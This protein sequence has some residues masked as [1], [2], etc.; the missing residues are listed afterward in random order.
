MSQADFAVS[1]AG[2]EGTVFSTIFRQTSFATFLTSF[3]SVVMLSQIF[4]RSGL[5]SA[6]TAALEL[7]DCL[8][9]SCAALMAASVDE[10][11][12]ELVPDEVP[13]LEPDEVPE[14]E[15]DEEVPVLLLLLLPQPTANAA[16]NI[17]AAANGPSLRIMWFPPGT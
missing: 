9:W 16:D 17:R 10:L 8:H 5:R 15:P 13:E 1:W 12:D 4:S 11:P 2:P 3:G 6:V 14:L 7:M